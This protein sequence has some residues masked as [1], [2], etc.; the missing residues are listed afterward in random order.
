MG[1]PPK[2]DG[3]AL[4]VDDTSDLTSSDDDAAPSA[5]GDEELGVAHEEGADDVGEDA[6][7]LDDTEGAEDEDDED[8]STEDGGWLDDAPFDE[9]DDD[10]GEGNADSIVGV[11]D[12]EGVDDE[13]PG[14]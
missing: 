11:S 10:T 3:E 4:G 8:D 1:R 14:D 13:T 9:E 5:L 2:S 6:G 12:D 7:W